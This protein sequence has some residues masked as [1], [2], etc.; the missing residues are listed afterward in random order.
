MSEKSESEINS[1]RQAV[2]PPSACSPQ[3]FGRRCGDCYWSLYDG[4]WCQNQNCRWWQ[5]SVPE[6]CVIKGLT[7]FEA[8]ILIDAGTAE[9]KLASLRQ[10]VTPTTES[11]DEFVARVRAIIEEN[12]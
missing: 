3:R 5:K 7:N 6:E 4:D 2:P 9:K 12:K 1:E 11:K 10:L 8:G